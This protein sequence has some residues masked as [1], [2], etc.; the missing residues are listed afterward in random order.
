MTWRVVSGDANSVV[1]PQPAALGPASFPGKHGPDSA[2]LGPG[3]CPAPLQ[4]RPSNFLG[5]ISSD[6][7]I[8]KLECKLCLKMLP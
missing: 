1:C 8:L 4:A 2:L 6:K 5:R 3:D 7:A